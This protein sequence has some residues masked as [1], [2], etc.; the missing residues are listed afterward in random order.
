MSSVP[1]TRYDDAF[2]KSQMDGSLRSAVRY[3]DFLS[4][5]YRPSSVVDVGCGRGTWLK[6][7]KDSGAQRVVGYDGAWNDKANMVDPSIDFHS[8]DLNKP[9]AVAER[10]DLAMSLEVA[11]HLAE[12]S[13]SGL[14][15]SLASL[16]DVV[17]FGAAYT[18]QGGTNH[19]NEQPP[20]YWAKMF[21]VHD[22][23]PFDLFR[24]IF[25]G[26]REVEYWYQQNTFLY[27]KR[28]T[29]VV[30]LLANLGHQPL[31]NIEFM[32]CVHPSLYNSKIQQPSKALIKQ[33]VTRAARRLKSSAS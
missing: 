21:A 6:A 29:V 13:A 25:W 19:I 33:L 10:F 1:D 2:Y 7:F 11:E 20:T 12:S 14:I 23:V 16:S 28:S 5:L 22:Y 3:V 9:I 17:M 24:P 30:G 27:V 18:E 4:T 32:D 15:G 31:K 8:V 26:D